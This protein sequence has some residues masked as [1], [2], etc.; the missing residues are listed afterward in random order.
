VDV[1]MSGPGVLRAEDA[2]TVVTATDVVR[3]LVAGRGD[4]QVAEYTSSDREGPPAHRHEWH[5]VEVVL[6]G[7]VDFWLDGG[8][9]RAGPGDVQ[10][11]PAGSSHSVR[12]PEAEARVLL[13]TIGAPYDQFARALVGVEGAEVVE[14]AA[15]HGVTLA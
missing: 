5:E 3:L 12:I 11:L 2:E 4:V 10:V 7:V 13:V 15:R 8:W 9:Y 1:D 6:D 14:V